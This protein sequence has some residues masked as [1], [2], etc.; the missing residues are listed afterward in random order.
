M[1]KFVFISVSLG[2]LLAL[3]FSC[4][5]GFANNHALSPAAPVPLI[6]KAIVWVWPTAIMLIDA[7]ANR[8]GYTLLVIS[9]IA[10]GLLYGFVAFCAGSVWSL[11]TSKGKWV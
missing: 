3:L 11:F 1:K 10:N 2:F 5:L 4:Y 9:W 8:A 7:D 6:S